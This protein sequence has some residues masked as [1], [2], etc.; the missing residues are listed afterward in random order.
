MQIFFVYMQFFFVYFIFFCTF[1]PKIKL[2][3]KCL[4]I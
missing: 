1:A 3:V 2:G 4:I